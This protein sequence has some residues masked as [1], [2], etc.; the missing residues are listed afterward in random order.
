MI[1]SASLRYARALADVAFEAGVPDRVFQELSEFLQVLRQ[2]EALSE[3]LVNPAI[4]FTSKRNIITELASRLG[5][6]PIVCNFLLLMLEKA[7]LPQLEEA[8]QGYAETLDERK[9]VVRAEVSFFPELHESAGQRLQEVLREV[10]GREVKLSFRTD[11]SLIGGVRV[12]I[13]STVFDGSIQTQLQ[14]IRRR[15][16]LE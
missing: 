15:L 1:S 2:H 3:A 7:R 6:L 10:T 16:A 12:Q 9:G 11:P 13:G 5:L 14:E 4:P 8:L